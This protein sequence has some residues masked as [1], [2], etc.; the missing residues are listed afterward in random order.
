LVVTQ[1]V[2]AFAFTSTPG[3]YTIQ[4]QPFKPVVTNRCSLRTSSATS[5]KAV[6]AEVD[7]A[8]TISTVTDYFLLNFR[9]LKGVLPLPLADFIA[10][11]P[12]G[13]TQQ[14]VIVTV[15]FT[16]F[17][18]PPNVLGGLI[19]YLGDFADKGGGWQP[20][21]IGSKLGRALGKGTY[22]T[23]YEA[24][25]TDEG[26]RKLR[27]GG[28]DSGGRVVVK[29]LIDQRQAEIE[30]YFNRRVTRAGGRGYFA[31]Y[32][33]GSQQLTQNAAAQRLDPRLLV[34][35][36][37][38]S[39]T[40]ENF[41]TDPNFPLNLEP[42]F[43]KRGQAPETLAF[44]PRARGEESDGK[45]EVEMLRRVMSDI[46]RATGLLH[47]CGIVHRDI[48]PANLLVAE[49][50][51]GQVIRV[52]DLGACA[53]LR[54]GFNYE[55]ES[56]IL[57][58]RY[59]PPEQYIM[60]QTT[61]R[62]PAGILALLAAPF[63]WTTQSPDLFDSYTSGIV[64][65][66][67]SLPQ[68]RGIGGTKIVNSQLKSV[69]NDP[70]AWRTAYGR[71]YDFSLLD[72]QNGAGWSLVCKLLTPKKSRMSVTAALGHRFFRPDGLS[73]VGLQP[74]GSKTLTRSLKT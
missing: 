40:V 68:I 52:I 47:T 62:P 11:T 48:K 45:R 31:S 4:R 72:R 23:A 22:G 61:P 42:Y 35:E 13:I 56:G 60:P 12:Q 6:I 58:P 37:E 46:L 63:L 66:Q 27:N 73:S 8:S 28:R 15:V 49:T 25:P 7:A 69:D 21:D 59:G 17:T 32:L 65:L 41:M 9:I 5:I 67:M 24:F 10:T 51:R 3:S 16:Y 14:L 43:Y 70:E 44:T 19:D 71:N 54:N 30:A 1:A 18:T 26:L 2:G 38:G 57:D 36:F 34:W 74:T 33:G 20:S 50:P 53:D 29:K 39:R 64:L 55:P